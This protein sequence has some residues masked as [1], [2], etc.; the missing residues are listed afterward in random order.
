MCHIFLQMS[1]QRW[2]LNQ[3]V[4]SNSSKYSSFTLSY[5]KA[6][7]S[8]WYFCSI[9]LRVFKDRKRSGQ[10]TVFSSTEDRFMCKVVTHSPISPSKQFRVPLMENGTV[11]STKTIQRWLSLEF[12]LKSRK[13][14]RP[15]TR[16]T[17]VINK[18]RLALATRRASWDIQISRMVLDMKR[19]LDNLNLGFIQLKRNVHF[20]STDHGSRLFYRPTTIRMSTKSHKGT[21]RARFLEG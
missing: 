8:V 11:V 21:N 19:D 2:V 17:R 6:R 1:L 20:D 10:P 5:F 14:A 4:N 12:D 18:E 7:S 13:H 3:S 9:K 15:T 16:F